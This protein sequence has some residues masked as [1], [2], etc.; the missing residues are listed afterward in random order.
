MFLILFEFAK[1]RRVEGTW[2]K[3]EEV[4]LL[5]ISRGLGIISE[6]VF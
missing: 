6:F 4:S 1:I 3:K 2:S 5:H